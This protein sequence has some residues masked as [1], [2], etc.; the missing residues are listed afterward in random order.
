MTDCIH[1]S[2]CDVSKC[3][4]QAY[5]QC[6]GCAR[7]ERNIEQLMVIHGGCVSCKDCEA[8]QFCD[9]KSNL[10][11][12]CLRVMCDYIIAKEQG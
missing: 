10:H 5:K 7:L 4:C 11:K 1:A 8:V 3:P 2:E 6:K 12:E 9:T